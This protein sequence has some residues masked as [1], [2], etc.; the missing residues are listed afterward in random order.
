MTALFEAKFNPAELRDKRGKWSHGSLSKAIGA[1]QVRTRMG[2]NGHDIDR[3]SSKGFRVRLKSG[4]VQHYNQPDDAARAA[5]EEKHH[6]APGFKEPLRPRLIKVDESKPKPVK[7]EPS[8]RRAP[9]VDPTVGLGAH[10]SKKG[11]MS[12]LELAFVEEHKNAS[13][14]P[15]GFQVDRRDRD[16][17]TVIDN[18]TMYAKVPVEARTYLA[19]RGAELYFGERPVTQLDDL[20]DLAQYKPSGYSKGQ[21]FSKVAAMVTMRGALPHPV[22][23]IGGGHRTYGSGSINVSAHEAGHALDFSK[24][25]RPG[26]GNLSEDDEFLAVY[27]KVVNNFN[28]KPY[29]VQAGNPTQGAKEFWAETFAA[30]AETR[31]MPKDQQELRARKM[32][33]AVGARLGASKDT[34]DRGGTKTSLAQVMLG[35]HLIAYFDKVQAGLQNGQ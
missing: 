30:W 26:V 2:V 10:P 3:T 22:V 33:M 28:I 13:G 11:M 1:L 17:Q 16:K 21:T 18:L 32:M 20:S 27:D 15:G 23:A 9:M 7:R 34:A 35:E 12:P 8:K 4:E 6:D 24:G 5:L 29:Y 14:L 19:A 31:D 25:T